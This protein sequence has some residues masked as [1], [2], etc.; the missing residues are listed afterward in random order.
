MTFGNL[1]RKGRY[2]KLKNIP[3]PNRTL[4]F[5]GLLLTIV[6]GI[7]SRAEAENIHQLSSH[8]KWIPGPVNGV[9]INKG[10]KSLAIYGD[11]RSEPDAAEIVLL[12]HHRRDVVWAAKK[13]IQ[14]G[15]KTIAP[16]GEKPLFED[17]ESYWK[18]FTQERFQDYKQQSTKILAES[19]PIKRF[20]QSGETIEWKDVKIEVMDTP[21]FTRGSITYTTILDDRRIAFTGDLIY[22]DGKV[23]DLYSF[24]DEVLEANIRGYH[25]YGGRFSSL[26]D[27]LKRVA[28]W[29]PDW[30]IPAR[31]PIIKN[32]KHALH[33][34]IDRIRDIYKNYL[35]TSA[36]YWYFK[37]PHIKACVERVLGPGAEFEVM[38]Y[39]HYEE[40][41][42]WV[43]STATS[44]IIT[45]EN[46][47]A[48]LLDCGYQ[49][50]IDQVLEMQKRGEIKKIDAI[51]VTHYHDDHTD[52]VQNAAEIF[53][54]PVYATEEIVHLLEN[55]GAY[56][57]PAQTDNPIRNVIG[58]KNG[59]EMKWNEFNLQFHFLPGQTYYHGGLFVTTPGEKSLFFIGDAFTPSGIDDYCLLNR[60]LI[61]EDSGYLYCLKKLKETKGPFYLINEHVDYIFQFNENQ[62]K[63]LTDRY[64]ER[65]KMIREV[66]PWDDPNYMVDE[67]WIRFNSYGRSVSAGD[68]FKSRLIVENHSPVNRRFELQVNS[69]QNWEIQPRKATLI[70][71]PRQIGSIDFHVTIPENETTPISLL[72]C[73]VKSGDGMQFRE[74]TESM[75]EINNKP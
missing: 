66:S 62:L 73:D 47:H 37:E 70:L 59:S 18:N 23:L 36:L 69:S 8:L 55:P 7:S 34:L 4:I 41:P 44:R 28:A 12:T 68:T 15:S 13:L 71:K 17:P 49:K 67:Q 32:P 33:T 6:V 58:R 11:P 5:F 40:K 60:N 50:V 54:C 75:I 39:S 43:F 35:S 21:G 52:Q 3:R 29:N 24:Q 20:V 2:M 26:I 16:A 74:W 31:G 30:I 27:S 9:L 14:N 56:H 53:D 57:L 64:R 10:D 65:A 51:F 1:R 46:G 19:L 72:T 25:G 63:Y 38:P 42:E 48:I 45:S 22:G 61:H